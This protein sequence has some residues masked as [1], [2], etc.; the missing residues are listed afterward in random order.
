M[1]QVH[2]LHLISEDEYNLYLSKN[3]EYEK[4]IQAAEISYKQFELLQK[5]ISYSYSIKYK[6]K[7]SNMIVGHNIP[8]KL[9]HRKD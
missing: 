2:E 8:N 4:L 9:L 6:K 3:E 5:K 7:V 1:R